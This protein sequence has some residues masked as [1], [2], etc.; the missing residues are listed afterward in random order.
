M[1]GSIPF[2][3]ARRASPTVDI[4]SR[5]AP[6][7]V[8]NASGPAPATTPS[9]MALI[10]SSLKDFALAA[11]S[12]HSVASTSSVATKV[13]PSAT[14]APLEDAAHTGA[15]SECSCGCGLITWPENLKQTTDLMLRPTPPTPA[16]VNPVYTK[17]DALVVVASTSSVKGKG[18]ARAV[19]DGSLYA[20]STRLAGALTE[21][22]DMTTIF[23]QTRKDMQEI[24]DALDELS[25]AI[26]R[27]TD[28]V[29]E[30]S[31]ATVQVVRENIRA[32]H[33]RAKTRAKELRAAGERLLSS[34]S[35]QVRGRVALAKENAQTLRD[36]VRVRREESFRVRREWHEVRRER[37]MERRAVRHERRARRAQSVGI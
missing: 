13:V 26:S 24:L 4:I 27:Q 7:P 19:E 15:P 36:N 5:P 12:P 29:W 32:R 11:I 8:V 2:S 9:S 37:R 22:L 17:G 28:A 14:A 1:N 18:K 21:Y 25:R 31:K 35:A 6:S 23:A 16:L 3:G 33:E 34:V 10:P 20:L 30:Q